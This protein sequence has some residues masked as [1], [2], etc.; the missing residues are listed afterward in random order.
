M[1]KIPQTALQANVP[2]PGWKLFSTG[3]WFLF[4]SS[5][6]IGLKKTRW[7]IDSI[8]ISAPLLCIAMFFLLTISL[9]NKGNRLRHL[10]PNVRLVFEI[11]LI[12]GLITALRGF[13][14]FRITNFRDNLGIRLFAW[15]WLIPAVALM[16]VYPQ[17][18]R[19]LLTVIAKQGRIGLI[20]L[21]VAWLPPLRLHTM[22]GMCWGC[23]ALL[24]FWHYLSK[25]ARRVALA[26]A[27]LS[28]FFSVL[29]SGRSEII[30]AGF[31]MIAA[32]YIGMKRNDKFSGRRRFQILAGAVMVLGLVYYAAHH[33]S[34]PILS[35]RTESRITTFKEDL[36]VNTRTSGEVGLYQDF[37]NAMDAWD[38]FWGR[39]SIGVYRSMQ[40]GDLDRVLIE[41]GYFH[42]LLKGGVI[43]LVLMLLLA[44]PA[45]YKGF[46]RSHNWVVKGFAFIVLGWLIDMVPYGIP[47]ASPPYLLFW[48]A[49][50]VCLNPQLRRKTDAQMEAFLPVGG[51]RFGRL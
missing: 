39:G 50:G 33:S 14:S 30:S 22:F 16:S 47:A 7:Q 5:A 11:L 32:S 23:S 4:L 12:W 28:V 10:D 9:Q 1:K 42:V 38:L 6:V 18:F 26:G 15:A 8:Y 24:L 17:N 41:C 19:H 29:A 45:A 27:F 31:F 37:L 21:A 25:G 51:V 48:L 46:F 35:D 36:F 40:S 20:F 44:I 43:M 34:L 2:S 13:T 3:L 49:I